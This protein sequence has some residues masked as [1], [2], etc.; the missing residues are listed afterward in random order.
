MR[1]AITYIYL[2]FSRFFHGEKM[3]QSKKEDL[4]TTSEDSE[5]IYHCPSC[6]QECTQEE[7]ESGFCLDCDQIEMF[8]D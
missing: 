7:F 8:G 6:G 2:R 4:T 5:K 1:S 3:E